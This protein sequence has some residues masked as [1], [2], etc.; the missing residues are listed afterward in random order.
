MLIS[1]SV[2]CIN[3]KNIFLTKCIQL[4]FKKKLITSKVTTKM[5]NIYLFFS[6]MLFIS[7]NYKTYQLLR[8]EK[9]VSG[10]ETTKMSS[11]QLKIYLFH[12]CSA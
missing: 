1:I 8:S 5:S 2:K 11:V 3:F 4:F 10:K 6:Q 9:T 7:N 12:V